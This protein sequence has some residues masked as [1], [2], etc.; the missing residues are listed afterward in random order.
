MIFGRKNDAREPTVG[1]EV[2]TSDEEVL[3]TVAAVSDQDLEVTGGA[4]DRPHAWCVPRSAVSKVDG[5]TVRLSASRAQIAAK[6]WERTAGAGAAG[7]TALA[8]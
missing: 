1:H 3:G 5:Q 6:G 2:L 7:S 8:E 4:I